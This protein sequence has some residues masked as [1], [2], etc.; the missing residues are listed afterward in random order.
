MFLMCVICCSLVVRGSM[1]VGGWWLVAVV[2]CSLCGVCC[3]VFVA[4]ALV[5]CWLS[6]FYDLMIVAR[7]VSFAVVLLAMLVMCCLLLECLLVACC[8]LCV[9]CCLRCVRC[10]LFVACCLLV[11]GCCLLFDVCWLLI[12][13][14]RYSMGVRCCVCWRGIC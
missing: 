14:F 9:V 4:V 12:G 7:C 5:D 6:V 8:V 11:V 2:R 1:V 10:S 3:V 13:G